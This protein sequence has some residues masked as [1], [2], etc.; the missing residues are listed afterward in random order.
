M[1]RR[2]LHRK[3]ILRTLHPGFSGYHFLGTEERAGQT[4][5]LLRAPY[6]NFVRVNSHI[7]RGYRGRVPVAS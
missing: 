3:R 1:R 6:R 2:T 5:W 7:R 4:F